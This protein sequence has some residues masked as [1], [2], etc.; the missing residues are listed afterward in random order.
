MPEFALA[1][2]GSEPKRVL[3]EASAGVDGV[4]SELYHPFT[5]LLDHPFVRRPPWCSTGWPF[6]HR[7]AFGII[8]QCWPTGI[9]C[10]L[11]IACFLLA[12]V[13]GVTQV[14]LSH[15]QAAEPYPCTHPRRG[16]L[17][18]PQPPQ[19]GE[20]QGPSHPQPDPRS[21]QAMPR[22]GPY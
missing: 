12:A 3:V 8:F 6:T 16:S 11:R 14:E 2:P 10:C 21:K 17:M 7:G 4:C 19:T 1:P 13:L 22:S 20:R 15:C 18:K 9:I 5:F